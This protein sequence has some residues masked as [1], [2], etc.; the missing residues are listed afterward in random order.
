[1]AQDIKSQNIKIQTSKNQN[2][3]L[4]TFDL[5][6]AALKEDMPQGDVTTDSLGVKPKLSEAILKAKADVVLSGSTLFEQTMTFLEPNAK[7]KWLFNDGDLVYKG[8][9]ICVVEGDL[10]QILKAERV[11]LNF[12]GRLSGIAT[13]TRQFV[14]AVEGT[15]TKILDTRKTTPL[16][17]DLEKK[18]VAHGGGT[19]HRFNLSDAIMVKDNH[20][21]LMGGITAA[22][23][24]IRR[25]CDLPVEVEASTLEQVKECVSLNIHR[26]LLD[27]MSN[28]LL[29]EVLPH[30]PKHIQTEASGNMT[31]ERVRSVAET[32]VDFISVGAL[33]HSAPVADVSLTFDWGE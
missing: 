30:I 24:R 5:I 33:T 20:I 32:G 7:I 17:R 18:A 1:M 4:S 25:H 26:I 12:L 21:T 10:I 9:N 3:P 6:K 27:N 23:E 22:V 29:K 19:N 28:E 13:L 31:L 14:K 15:K 11:A 16:F 2:S 8:Q